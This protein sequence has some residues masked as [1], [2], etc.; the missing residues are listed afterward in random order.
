LI[1]TAKWLELRMIEYVFGFK[2]SGKL[3]T[4]ADNSEKRYYSKL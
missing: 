4:K 3:N 1:R 2:G